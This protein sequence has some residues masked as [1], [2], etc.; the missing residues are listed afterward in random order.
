MADVNND[1]AV[2]ISD[3]TILVDIVV[4][5]INIS[6]NEPTTAPDKPTL[7]AS[8]IVL[9]IFSDTYGFPINYEEYKYPGGWYKC[10]VTNTIVKGTT[11][12]KAEYAEDANDT[13]TGQAGFWQTAGR[14]AAGAKKVYL[15]AFTPDATQLTIEILNSN[16]EKVADLVVPLEKGKWN[17]VSASVEGLDLSSLGNVS[18]RAGHSTIWFTDF[19]FA[20]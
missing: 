5:G 6:T 2:T 18:V 10:T 3:V 12:V 9:S 7:P 8:D 15:T 11:A 17:Y 16:D 19:F 1:K 14:S 4:N 20:R 13:W